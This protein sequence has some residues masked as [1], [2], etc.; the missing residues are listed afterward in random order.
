MRDWAT[1]NLFRS[2]LPRG[3]RPEGQSRDEPARRF[4]PRSHAGSDSD[5]RYDF[6]GMAAFRS[7]LPRGERHDQR[8]RTDSQGYLT[9]LAHH[10]AH[11]RWN[12]H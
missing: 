3:E 11:D 12:Q 2:T 1:A 7:T 5:D 9:F 6:H 4:D 8:L 10:G